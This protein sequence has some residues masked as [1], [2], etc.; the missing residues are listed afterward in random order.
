MPVQMGIIAVAFV[1]YMASTAS[2]VERGIK[3]L[4]NFNLALAA[5]LPAPDGPVLP[6]RGSRA[7]PTECRRTRRG[8]GAVGARWIL[9]NAGAAAAARA[10]VAPGTARPPAP[11]GAAARLVRRARPA[12]PAPPPGAQRGANGA[13]FRAIGRARTVPAYR[14]RRNDAVLARFSAHSPRRARTRV[15]S[16]AEPMV[17]SPHVAAPHQPEADPPARRR[18]ARGCRCVAARTRAYYLDHKCGTNRHVS[19]KQPRFDQTPHRQRRG[20]FHFGN[21]ENFKSPRNAPTHTLPRK[22][23]P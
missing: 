4:S 18:V 9:R 19:D 22:S 21:R 23:A 6:H 10:Q 2:G 17:T 3:W 7:T 12:P 20:V 13:S 15:D 1:L 8:S 5:L 16:P 11:V 14:F